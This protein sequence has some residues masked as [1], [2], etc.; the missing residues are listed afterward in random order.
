VAGSAMGV[1]RAELA[2]KGQT[3]LGQLLVAVT[4]GVL[5]AVMVWSASF[6]A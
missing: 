4:V 5:T 6:P 2:V 1:R 3:M